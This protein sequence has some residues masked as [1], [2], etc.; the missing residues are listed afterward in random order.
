MNQFK[1]FVFVVAMAVFGIFIVLPILFGSWYTISAGHRGVIV[2]LGAVQSGVQQ[3]GFHL[4][5]PWIESVYEI[6]VQVQADAVDAN[7]ASHDL[8]I[9]T[10]K[11][12][13]NFNLVPEAVDQVYQKIGVDYMPKIIS[14]AVQ[15]IVKAVTAKYTAEELITKRADVKMQIK[16]LLTERLITYHIQVV[17]ISIADFNFSKAFNDAIEAKQV[18]EQQ[19]STARNR[20]ESVKV[21]AEQKIAQ[22]QAEAKSLELQKAQITPD[23]IKLREVENQTKAIEKW[24]GVLPT[25][26]TGVIPFVNIGGK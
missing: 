12:V 23:L 5:L 6:N 19:V 26:T 25:Y 10:T 16:Q 24:N 9:V 8:Q 20:L 18:A 22:A 7:A 14:P 17:D 2:R 1:M 15:E 3:E 11:I 21:E 13:T 4:K